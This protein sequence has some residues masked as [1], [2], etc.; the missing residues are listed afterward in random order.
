MLQTTT[1][2]S[3]IIE[4]LKEAQRQNYYFVSY[5]MSHFEK[6]ADL[7]KCLEE[8][9]TYD[10]VATGAYEFYLENYSEEGY[11]TYLEEFETYYQT[12]EQSEPL[13]YDEWLYTDFADR[14]EEN[15]EVMDEFTFM[16]FNEI[17]TVI[18]E[19][20][21]ELEELKNPIEANLPNY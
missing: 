12:P 20:E 16:S 3:V 9:H 7:E 19:L 13:S 15:C 8:C 10:Y 14:H 2:L 11:Q 17:E 1:L 5:D 21:E 6:W 4:N 18:Q